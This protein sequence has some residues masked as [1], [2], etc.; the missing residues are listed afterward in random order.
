MKTTERPFWVSRRRD[1][2]I[3]RDIADV[4]IA[5]EVVLFEEDEEEAP[6]LS[7]CAHTFFII[8]KFNGIHMGKAK[9][10]NTVVS[11]IAAVKSLGDWLNALG[12]GRKNRLPARLIARVMTYFSRAATRGYLSLILC[13]RFVFLATARI[14][15]TAQHKVS[16]PS[17]SAH[18]IELN[19]INAFGMSSGWIPSRSSLSFIVSCFCKIYTGFCVFEMIDINNLMLN[20]DLLM[21]L[22]K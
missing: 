7:S 17:H 1:S 20:D 19:M 4:A 15:R 16:T 3:V 14:G 2:S 18:N 22:A 9:L 13:S 5:F 8:L 12:M 6:P 10:Y 11:A 21:D